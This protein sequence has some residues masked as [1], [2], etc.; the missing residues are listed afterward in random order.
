RTLCRFLAVVFLFLNYLLIV[1][2]VS[3]ISHDAFDSFLVAELILRPGA[4][5]FRL[6]PARGF[7][8]FRR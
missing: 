1:R 7:Q 4:E 5:E 2:N 3:G 8:P 6:R